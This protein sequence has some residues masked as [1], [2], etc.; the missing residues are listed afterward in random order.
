MEIPTFRQLKLHIVELVPLD[1]DYLHILV[2]AAILLAL[3]APARAEQEQA[4]RSWPRTGLV[5]SGGGARGGAH[6]G[7]LKVMEELRVPV[8]FVVG[9]SMGS[10]VGGLYA[11]GM[12]PEEMEATFREV[13]WV[14]AFHDEPER[15]RCIEPLL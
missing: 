14:A 15:N 11:S 5:L 8:D 4:E 10:I 13:D 12:S 1:R 3:C 2:G 7:V 6:V 9:T